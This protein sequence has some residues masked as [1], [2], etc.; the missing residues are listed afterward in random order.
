MNPYSY[1]SEE[2]RVNMHL[3]KTTSRWLHY[4]VDFPTAYNAQHEGNDTVLGEY[5]QP[6]HVDRAPL[7]IIVHG[8]GDRSVSLADSWHE[9][10][11]KRG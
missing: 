10:W 8:W 7:A 2:P 4:A 1:Q 11:Q 6:R 5:F 3:T 9:L